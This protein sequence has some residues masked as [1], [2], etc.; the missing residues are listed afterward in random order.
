MKQEK[1][2]KIR[3]PLEVRI[4]MFSTLAAG[5]A[6]FAALVVSAFF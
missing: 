6:V 3:L 5:C 4:A 1:E 2:R